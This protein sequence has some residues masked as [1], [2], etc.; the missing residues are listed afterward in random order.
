ML[1]QATIY[2]L[3]SSFAIIHFSFLFVYSS[4]IRE[5]G[6]EEE[7]KKS[8]V[9]ALSTFES[10]QNWWCQLCLKQSSVGCRLALLPGSGDS[11]TFCILSC[12]DQPTFLPFTAKHGALRRSPQT[13]MS[14]SSSLDLFPGLTVLKKS[15]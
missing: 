13:H 15:T 11:L 9:A 7:R 8:A 6:G 4:K 5:G 3:N 12:Y 2:L 1:C 14:V 10:V